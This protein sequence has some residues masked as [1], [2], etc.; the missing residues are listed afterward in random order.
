MTENEPIDIAKARAQ[1]EL[2]QEKF[3]FLDALAG[4]EYPTQDVEI[5][6]NEGA[7]HKID[8]L[9]KDHTEAWDTE[10]AN[11]IQNQIDA[12][13]EKAQ[14]SRFI[15]H[16]TGIPVD[17]YD[18]LVDL[19]TEQFP[20]EYTESRNPLTFALE[21]EVKNNPQR[22]MFFRTHLWAKCITSVSAPGGE[23]DDNITPEWAATLLGKAPIMALGR[24]EIA[25]EELRMV[26][27]WMDRLENEDFLAKS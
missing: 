15:I 4:R 26:S 18:A 7:A 6:L 27:D 21:R 14:A 13:R 12:L 5:F 8:R 17:E 23:V 1:A 10:Q 20:L 16:L 19:A 9:E 22:E 2:T 11:L 25:M 3:S 24:I